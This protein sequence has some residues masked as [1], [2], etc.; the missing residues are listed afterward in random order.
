VTNS[1]RKGKG[2]G[3]VVTGKHV[4]Q[5][6]DLLLLNFCLSIAA[7]VIRGLS[8]LLLR[9]RN[10]MGGLLMLSCSR[11]SDDVCIAAHRLHIKLKHNH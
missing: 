9:G 4:T 1:T 5:I 10:V 11:K 8:C 7:N 2:K 6:A 3:T